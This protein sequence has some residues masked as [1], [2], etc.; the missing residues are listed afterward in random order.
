M[1]TIQILQLYS[2]N[3]S[4]DTMLMRMVRELLWSI[5]QFLGYIV[6]AI[7]AVTSKLFVLDSFYNNANVINFINSFKPLIVVLFGISF[8]TV[9]YQ[10]MFSQTKQFRKIGI[11]VLIAISVILV[12][13][14]AMDKMNTLTNTGVSAVIGDAPNITN[15]IIKENVT[16]LV[17]FDTLKYNNDA[18]KQLKSSNSIKLENIRQLDATTLMEPDVYSNF[19]LNNG[20]VF[21]RKIIID[22]SGNIAL[23]D[24]NQGW[25]TFWKEYYYRFDI[26]FFN[27]IVALGVIGSALAFTC[28]KLGQLIFELGYN[29]LLAMLVAPAD[30]NNGQRTKQ[31]IQNILSIFIVTFLIAVLLKFYILFIGIVA[32]IKGIVSLVLLVAGSFALID[33]PNIVEK[34][35]GIDAGLH[36]GFKTM[37]GAYL[38]GKTM[39]GGSRSLGNTAKSIGKT[40]KSVSSATGSGIGSVVGGG[41][42]VANGLYHNMDKDKK[43][44]E[45]NKK[46]MYDDINKKGTETKKE[47][48][49]NS[50]TI[51][52]NGKN[53]TPKPTSEPI[54]NNKSGSINGNI[55]PKDITENKNGNDS[56]KPASLYKEMEGNNSDNEIAGHT[57]SEPSSA[58]IQSSDNISSS[59]D[60]DSDSRQTI[61]Q[62]VKQSAKNNINE[63]VQRIQNSPIVQRTRKSYNLGRNTG[64]SIG[65]RNINKN[66]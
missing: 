65:N 59:A 47:P 10:L 19:K 24:L 11:N 52:G 13:P 33:G 42:G 8:C 1:S 36:S 37:A 48:K 55:V 23:G 66:K 14:M 40:A 26:N 3:F 25:M 49:N 16:D 39:A 64:Q 21:T 32:N 54:N 43:N 60:Q 5:I 45:N 58:P 44:K 35:F 6:D 63:K 27:I 15:Q 31:I 4:L 20:E 38:V 30:I 17:T 29:K 22:K 28:F 62:Y 50:N 57:I 46:S 56:E 9:G 18:I 34:L 2:T 41:A 51:N 61:G 53:T 7:S 12:L